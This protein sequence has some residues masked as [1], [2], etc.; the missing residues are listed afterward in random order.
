MSLF[1]KRMTLEGALAACSH[2]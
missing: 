1:W 2:S